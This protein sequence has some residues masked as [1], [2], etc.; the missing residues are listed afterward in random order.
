MKVYDKNVNM[1]FVETIQ[2]KAK[3][4]DNVKAYKCKLLKKMKI[5]EVSLMKNDF[6]LRQT[7]ACKEV[8]RNFKTSTTQKI[9]H[10]KFIDVVFCKDF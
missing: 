2:V 1:N 9:S 7:K 6:D 10:K 4:F 5:N 3:I 8:F